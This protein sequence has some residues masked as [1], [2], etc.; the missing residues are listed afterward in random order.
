MEYSTEGIVI[1]GSY[2]WGDNRKLRDVHIKTG[3]VNCDDDFSEELSESA[4]DL[5]GDTTTLFLRGRRVWLWWMMPARPGFLSSTTSCRC[6][7]ESS[8]QSIIFSTCSQ[9]SRRQGRTRL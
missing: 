7:V 3:L 1:S 4:V 5:S 8:R 6:L 9:R 2:V